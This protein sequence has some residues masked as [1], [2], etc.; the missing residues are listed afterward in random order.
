MAWVIHGFTT[1]Y[2][3][4]EVDSL[5]KLVFLDTAE[6]AANF[7]ITHLPE[8]SVPYYDFD[9]PYQTEYVPRD[10][11]AASIAAHAFLRLYKLTGNSTYFD[12]AEKTMESL[13]TDKYRADGK[14]EYQ[15]PAILA[16]GTVY[17]LN[18]D[19]DTAIVYA[20]FYFLRALDLYID[21]VSNVVPIF[22]AK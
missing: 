20:D 13:M 2:E 6:K 14:S 19:F 1:V 12:T 7:F 22:P 16:N 5:M 18:N 17:Y 21:L 4:A 11:A 3:E 8:D 9:A 10:T 15:L